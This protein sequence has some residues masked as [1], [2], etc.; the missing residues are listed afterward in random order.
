MT[1]C[2]PERSPRFDGN[3]SPDSRKLEMGKGKKRSGSRGSGT[4]RQIQRTA[5]ERQEAWLETGRPNDTF[6]LTHE[7]DVLYDEHRDEQAGTLVDP[8]F[9]RTWRP[10]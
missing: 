9:G 4:T 10:S 1:G 2:P 5:R 8:Y 3:S 7:L 6:R